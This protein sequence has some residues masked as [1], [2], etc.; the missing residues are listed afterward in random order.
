MFKLGISVSAS[1]VCNVYDAVVIVR[2]FL[3]EW[4]FDIAL[5]ITWFYLPRA[6]VQCKW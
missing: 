2:E 4:L 5:G 1:L 6:L 3:L